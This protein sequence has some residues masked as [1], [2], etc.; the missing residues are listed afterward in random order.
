M[1]DRRLVE[2][3]RTGDRNAQRE[4]FEQTSPRVYRLLF[5][6][7]GN[8]DDAS[9][10][11]QDT[12]VKGLTRI[13]EFDGRSSLITWLHRIAV[14][15]ALQ[16]QRRGKVLRR[17][18]NDLAAAQTEGYEDAARLT[19]FMDVEEALLAL[20][21]AERTM[22]LLRYQEGY[23]YRTI[24]E[25]T[26]LPQGTVASRLNRAREQLRDALQKAYGTMEEKP[27]PTHPTIEGKVRTDGDEVAALINI[28]DTERP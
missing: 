25:L 5:R 19:R 24:G 26:G 27:A 7:T 18:L 17:K 9:D 14:N 8:A 10:L 13:G 1:D 3:C 16:F 21:T 15:E 6:I 28:P 20:P 2:R 12:F 4:L 11:T 23:D 22:L